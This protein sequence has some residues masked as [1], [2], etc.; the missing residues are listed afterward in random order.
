M[1]VIRMSG[2]SAQE[3]V[4]LA[5]AGTAGPPNPMQRGAAGAVG[6]VKKADSV[7]QSGWR[8]H[9]PKGGILSKE[10]V[11]EWEAELFALPEQTFSATRLQ[12]DHAA[13]GLRL[14]LTAREALRACLGQTACAELP[15]ADKWKGKE[16]MDTALFGTIKAQDSNYDWT[17]GTLY[18]GSVTG[19][20]PSGGDPTARV[21]LAPQEGGEGGIDMGMLQ[22]P[23]PILF[24][25]ELVLFEDDLADNGAC[26]LSVKLRVMPT[27]WF[28]L[29]RM[30][31]RVDSVL[32]KVVDT[33]F[34]HA[35]G[36][37]NVVREV[38]VMQ[39]E[40]A[41]LKEVTTLRNSVP[42]PCFWPS[43]TV[44]S[45]GFPRTPCASLALTPAC[46][47]EGGRRGQGRP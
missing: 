30:H 24:F 40:W 46:V 11:D 17:Y 3:A 23:D 10:E 4:A 42:F 8:V 12:I 19:G 7:E 25:E 2:M 21:E 28:V 32:V 6:G 33:R 37:A 41:T 1:K 38:K 14:E 18:A 29:M 44:S 36:A 35:F 34:F 13:S 45:S 39:E 22:R 9:A 20:D 31:L 43:P 5:K 16:G 15:Y 27:C 47:P 26:T